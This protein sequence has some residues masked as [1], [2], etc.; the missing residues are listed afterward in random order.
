MV[1]TRVCAVPYQMINDWRTQREAS[2]ADAA[3]AADM[4]EDDMDERRSHD[5]QESLMSEES[6]FP[7]LSRNARQ[8]LK[9]KCGV[10]VFMAQSMM[11]TKMWQ[12][13]N[14]PGSPAGPAWFM[15]TDHVTVVHCQGNHESIL[16]GSTHFGDL[17]IIV[18]FLEHDLQHA[19]PHLQVDNAAGDEPQLAVTPRA[20]MLAVDP[21]P[22]RATSADSSSSSTNYVV[23]S[24][25][26]RTPTWFDICELH[27]SD[28]RSDGV[29]AL[30]A[31]GGGGNT[32]STHLAWAMPGTNAQLPLWAMSWGFAS[33][34][35][36]G[37]DQHG[38]SSARTAA[39]GGATLTRLTQHGV[40]VGL[41]DSTWGTSVPPRTSHVP[42]HLSLSAAGTV[43]AAAARPVRELEQHLV[44]AAMA[45]AEPARRRWRLTRGLSLEETEYR[46]RL[47]EVKTPNGSEFGDP[48]NAPSLEPPFKP[49]AFP[50]VVFVIPED[51]P[52][53]LWLMAK[54]AALAGSMPDLQCFALSL[55]RK[56][57]ESPLARKVAA[58]CLSSDLEAKILTQYIRGALYVRR[59]CPFHCRS[60]VSELNS[61]FRWFGA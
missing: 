33:E 44:N 55:P 23:G 25:V 56:V 29:Q 18:P 59:S 57:L 16:R 58:R 22:T 10:T 1:C 12:Y 13:T 20:Q 39:A 49:M 43:A 28:D 38:A 34:L 50:A 30:P 8:Q 37:T 48:L 51:G 31:G 61:G 21:K 14:W 17:D 47:E 35:T 5:S 54:S 3:A 46:R 2:E 52:N 6:F 36:V 40:L 27:G 15:C 24:L 53:A 42:T 32:K 11:T 7:L 19:W 4:D 9:V 60:G 41:T 45:M 26:G